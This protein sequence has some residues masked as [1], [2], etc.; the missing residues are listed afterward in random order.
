[1]EEAKYTPGPW[2][3]YKRHSVV[4]AK[5]TFVADCQ[6]MRDDW[7][8]DEA[9]A[10]LI[11]AAPELLEALDDMLIERTLEDYPMST[12]MAL[13]VEKAKAAISKARTHGR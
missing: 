6:S 7:G 10:R 2:E 4:G 3:L 11:S 8:E 12:H 9:N 13:A 1:M 5:W